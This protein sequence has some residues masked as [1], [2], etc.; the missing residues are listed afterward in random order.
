M[1][2][3]NRITF[4]NPDLLQR[5]FDESMAIEES[6]EFRAREQAELRDARRTFW[7]VHAPI[8]LVAMILAAVEVT[9]VSSALHSI[10]ADSWALTAVIVAGPILIAGG[11]L[12]PKSAAFTRRRIAFRQKV[13]NAIAGE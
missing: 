8:L 11:I 9:W 3:S 7:R 10:L 4:H 6:P 5:R 1:S 2:S 13:W 12:Y